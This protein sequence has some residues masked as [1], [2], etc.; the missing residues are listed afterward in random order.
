[1]YLY[2]TFEPGQVIGE[3]T[4]TLDSTLL[5]RW[6]EIFPQDSGG[7]SI[8]AGLTAVIFIRA[9]SDLL[10][11]R[12]PGNVHGAQT[13]EVRRLPQSG[14]TVVTSLSCAGKELRGER[15][16]VRFASET[17]SQA[18]DHLFSGLM[19]TLWAR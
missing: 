8:P 17:R 18:G 6:F 4:L 1:M 9:Y 19:T 16:W 10:Q 14:E 2:D 7:A 15:R 3:R 11:P 5:Q 13:F 12:P